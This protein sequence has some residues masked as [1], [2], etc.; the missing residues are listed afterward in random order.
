M[1]ARAAKKRGFRKK[2]KDEDAYNVFR[3]M[4]I[5][6]KSG[7]QKDRALEIIVNSSSSLQIR[8][9]LSTILKDIK[10]AKKIIAA[11]CLDT[12]QFTSASAPQQY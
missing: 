8:E 2:A 1:A 12:G 10:A 3:E 5:L 4:S 7:I 6:L 9:T 11:F